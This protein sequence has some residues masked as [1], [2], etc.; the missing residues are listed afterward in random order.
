MA[1]TLENIYQRAKK[2]NPF[3]NRKIFIEGVIAEWLELY[4]KPKNRIYKKG[5]VVLRNHLPAAI[6]L[7]GKSQAQIRL[8]YVYN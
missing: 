6:K 7:S 1:K 8:K 5:E 3:L 4:E 2:I